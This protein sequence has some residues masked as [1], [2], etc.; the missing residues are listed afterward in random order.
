MSPF[1]FAVGFVR[2]RVAGARMTEFYE[3]CRKSG[4]NPRRARRRSAGGDPS[5]L[6]TVTATARLSPFLSDGEVLFEEERGGVPILLRRLLYRP[7]M[8]AGIIAAILLL[9]ASSLFVWDVEISGTEAMSES[10]VREVLALA[11]LDRGSFLPALDP[12]R[13]SLAARQGEARLSFV[14]VN[15]RGTVAMVQVREAREGVL[16]EKRPA[17]L[18]ARCDGVV[19]MPLI[20]AGKCLVSE[21]EVVRAGQ[22]LASGLL[23][24]ENNGLRMTRAAG[25]VLARTVHTYEVFVPFSYEEQ[26]PMGGEGLEVSLLF[27]GFEGKV[28]KST[29]KSGVQCDIIKNVKEFSL[30]GGRT[31]PF[32]L[33]LTRTV[34]YTSVSAKRSV[35]EARALALAELSS[36]LEADSAGRTLLQKTTEA[37][38]DTKGVTL[39]CTVVAEED[40][41][42]VAEFQTAVE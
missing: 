35:A 25:Q 36:R 28:F 42:R 8:L 4:V 21:G 26:V 1:L 18:V 40:I 37:R 11:G 5:F 34:P 23:E 20:F 41:A 2:V 10:E 38:I 32:G 39:V 31:L 22:I 14:A 27:F 15:L 19:T 6:L 13:I 7:G 12:D 29:G 33:V 24:S 16:P 17:N 3:A 30:P 9:V